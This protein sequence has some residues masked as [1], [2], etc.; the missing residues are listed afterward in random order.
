MVSQQGS[1]RGRQGEQS[2][3]A[4][5]KYSLDGPSSWGSAVPLSSALQLPN[6]FHPILQRAPNTPSEG[7]LPL[8]QRERDEIGQ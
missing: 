1:L 2:P 5:Q 3:G 8:P 7:F 4:S 6:P